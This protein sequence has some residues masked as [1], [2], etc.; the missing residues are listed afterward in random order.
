MIFL[1]FAFMPPSSASQGVNL[2]EQA[3]LLSCN[4]GSGTGF[5]TAE[6]KIVTARHVVEGCINVTVEN[7]S[8]DVG[9]ATVSHMSESNDIAVLTT[10]KK[11][12]NVVT[13]DTQK[14]LNSSVIQIVGAPI[15]GLVLSSGKVVEVF[16][17]TSGY[18]FLLNIPAD[19]GNSGGPVF[20]NGKVI[21][22]VNAK[23]SEGDI[24]GLDATE[25]Q[26]QLKV[27][28]DGG[29]RSIVTTVIKN[30]ASLAVSVLLNVFLLI[31]ILTS[32]VV[33]KRS[34]ANR[35]VISI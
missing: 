5:Y 6:N 14:L 30:E 32:L 8:G 9:V 35:I 15:D 26:K 12:A 13:L 29:D 18:D 11:I 17:K 21:G 28:L 19:F 31:F 34:S 20:L 22:L 16:N 23:N 10:D 27:D 1:S 24:L 33:R 7:N 25:I 4:E 2:I 3:V